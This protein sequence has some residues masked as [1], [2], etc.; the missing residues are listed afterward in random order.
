MDCSRFPFHRLPVLPAARRLGKHQQPQI[1]IW[2]NAGVYIVSSRK[3]P[4]GTTVKILRQNQENRASCFG[5]KSFCRDSQSVNAEHIT[6]FRHR[7]AER[8]FILSLNYWNGNGTLQTVRDRYT[9]QNISSANRA[10]TSALPNETLAGSVSLTPRCRLKPFRR[11]FRR[12]FKGR[13]SQVF[14]Q[15]KIP[16]L[17]AFRRPYGNMKPPDFCLFRHALPPASPLRT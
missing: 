1:G 13:G 15:I 9:Q 5:I 11:H 4:S 7:N 16:P 3:L 10:G 17:P 8:F 14:R 6:V 2:G 12:R